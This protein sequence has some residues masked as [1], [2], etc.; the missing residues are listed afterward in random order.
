MVISAATGSTAP[1]ST[2]I[3]K[4]FLFAIPSASKG[5]ETIAPSGKFWIAMPSD[6]VSAAAAVIP[7][8]PASSPAYTTP[9][10]MPSGIL[11]SVTARIS[12]VVRLNPLLGPSFC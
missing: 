7:D 11:C 8:E 12:L 6:S 1:E 9:T 4:V 5:M 2:P 3:A 10:A